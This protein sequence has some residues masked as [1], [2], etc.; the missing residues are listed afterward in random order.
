VSVKEAR[1]AAKRRNPDAL[2]DALIALSEKE[3]RSLHDELLELTKAVPSPNDRDPALDRCFFIALW[4]TGTSRDVRNAIASWRFVPDPRI[5]DVV[6]ARPHKT[7]DAL[8]RT[9]LRND[10]DRGPWFIIRDLIRSGVIPHP[11]TE[12]Y[13][14]HL[15]RALPFPTLNVSIGKHPE[16]RLASAVV[17]QLQDDGPLPEELLRALEIEEAVNTLTNAYVGDAWLLAFEE[18]LRAG[19]YRRERLLDV[20]V[21]G[22]LRDF[23][24]SASAFFRKL[25]DRLDPDSAEIAERLDMLVRIVASSNPGEQAAAAKLIAKAAKSGSAIDHHAVA[26]AVATPLTGSHKGA[27]M[28]ALRL[29][30]DSAMPSELQAGAAVHGLG[31]PHADVQERAL[32][33]I[34]QC[35][36]NVPAGVRADAMVWI[37]VVAPALHDRVVCV[38]GVESL[39]A[40]VEVY[41]GDLSVRRSAIAMPLGSNIVELL[42]AVERNEM[43]GTLRFDSF[44]FPTGAAPVEPIADVADLVAVVTAVLGGSGTPLDLERVIDGFGRHDPSRV[45]DS[46]L[47]PMRAAAEAVENPFAS[48]GWYGWGVRGIVSLAALYWSTRRVPPPLPYLAP[49]KKKRFRATPQLAHDLVQPK[50]DADGQ[51]WAAAFDGSS[52]SAGLSGFVSAR[53]WEAV[54]AGV[55][56]PRPSLA[57][58]TSTDGWLAD[59]ELIDRLD[60]HRSLK[61]APSRFDAVQALLRLR[62]ARGTDEYAESMDDPVALAVQAFH[63][64]SQADLDQGLAQAIASQVGPRAVRLVTFPKV[65]YQPEITVLRYDIGVG[66]D[67]LRRDDPVGQLLAELSAPKD[68]PVVNVRWT[69]VGTALSSSDQLLVDWTTIGLPR[70]RELV[71]ARAAS[72]LAE[73]PDANRST[74]CLHSLVSAASDP[75]LDFTF[76]VNALLAVALSD[77]NVVTSSAAADLLHDAATDGRLDAQLLGDVLAQLSNGAVVKPARFAKAAASVVPTSPLVAERVRQMLC[78]WLG[79]VDG[80]PRDLHAVLETLE[81]ACDRSG[82]GVDAQAALDKL[83]EASSGSSKRAKSAKRLLDLPAEPPAPAIS[84]A[85]HALLD[86]AERWHAA[87]A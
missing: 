16:E 37:D 42:A 40:P 78:T 6:A 34:E 54:C 80:L 75:D 86:R 13:Y 50:R 46:L 71:A 57:L 25:F 3:R 74:D 30:G 10:W 76:G 29:I 9:A 5:A 43:P 41:H 87:G 4:G 49:A 20:G 65:D 68:R 81:L 53:L 8:T 21:D 27:A 60:R 31:H 61:V 62:S 32:H 64:G 69:D 55:G 33:I 1:R 83:H 58:P 66:T 52:Y 56:K 24:K 67:Q 15:V 84:L 11:E 22:Q 35:G 82:T 2:A 19:V 38:A 26:A 77:R 36:E 17:T 85:G 28:A 59:D 12:E 14:E 72:M 51:W 47:S 70:H 48:G 23:R 18:A 44:E 79:L 63:S 7:I 73:D 45:S 39:A